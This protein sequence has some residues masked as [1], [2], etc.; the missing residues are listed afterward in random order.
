MYRIAVKAFSL[1]DAGLR[2]RWLLLI[3]MA[4][5]AAALESLG[6][7]LVFLLIRLVDDP[8]QSSTIPGLSGLRDLFGFSTDGAFLI[9]LSCFIAVFFVAKNAFRLYETYRR[10]SCASQT[11]VELSS[12]LMKAYLDAPYIFHLRMNSADLIR[13]THSAVQDA[14]RTV[15]NSA[16]AAVSECLIV[17]G[18][19]VVLCFS[20]PGPTLIGGVV[21]G[22]AA[23]VLLRVMQAQYSKWGEANHALDGAVLRALQQAFLGVKEVKVLGREAFFSNAYERSARALARV[24]VLAKTIHVAPRLIVEVIFVVGLALAIVFGAGDG[25]SNGKLLPLLGLFAYTLLRLLPSVHMIV[26]HGNNV[27]FG[28][29]A[30]DQVHDDWMSFVKPKSTQAEKHREPLPSP[31]SV[32]FEKTAF[33]YPKA[34]KPAVADI[35]L[36]IR[37]GEVVGIVGPTG[38]GKTT[39]VN[40]FLGLLEPTSGQVL[41]GSADILRHRR[42]WQAKIGYV[43]QQVFLFDDTLRRNIALGQN[44]AAEDSERLNEAIR[45]AQLED[46]V[47]ALPDGLDTLV[48]E[49]GVRI[50]GGERQRVAAA[51]ALYRDPEILVFDEA[52]SALDHKTELALAKAIQEFQGRK[53]VIIIA[54]RMSTVRSC[55]RLLFLV[56]GRIADQGPYE[57]LVKRNPDFREIAGLVDQ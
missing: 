24:H 54:H 26:F 8:T 43:P 4:V 55:D 23:A 40:L 27:R 19:L 38:A 20:A 37:R 57:D 17:L 29:A 48:G 53:T 16:V 46:F 42:A 34:L 56:D 28:G 45:I 52:T 21:L 30:V 2:R 47:A 12:R 44:A 36:E 1:L 6:A 3:P 22:I 18:L 39:L 51:R 7:L 10:E 5:A 32:S 25:M 49:D 11:A 14:S 50:S 35:D 33:T 13:N 41:A 9:F 31:Q 15:M